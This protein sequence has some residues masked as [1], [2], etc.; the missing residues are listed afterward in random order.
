VA[1][2]LRVLLSAPYLRYL[3]VLLYGSGPVRFLPLLILPLGLV[4]I[5]LGLVSIG[6]GLVS[7]GPG[8]V[9]IG[10]GLVSLGLVSL[11]LGLVSIGLGLL[12]MP[13]CWSLLS[14]PLCWSLPPL[15]GYTL[16][17]GPSSPWV[18]PLSGSLLS[19]GP[20]STRVPPLSRF[21]P[22][23]PLSGSTLSGVTLWPPRSKGCLQVSD[24]RVCGPAAHTRSPLH[25][26]HGR[27]HQESPGVTRSHQESPGVTRSVA[28][29]LRIS[30][31][32]KGRYRYPAQV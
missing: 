5:G 14:Q 3:R 19:L 31:T 4:S 8:L 2:Y 23:P 21:L 22:S 30:S 17:L 26:D 12:S 13:L 32:L 1:Q 9:S 25:S 15:P 28:R 18:H 24:R 20:S 29:T 6:P 16:S 7:I 10:P 27:S 11:G